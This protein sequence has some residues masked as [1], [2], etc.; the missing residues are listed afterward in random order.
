MLVLSD[1]KNSME[2]FVS[3]LG[4]RF[5]K[6]MKLSFEDAAKYDAMALIIFTKKI[7]IKHEEKGGR[8]MI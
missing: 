7:R 3:F 6:S 5:W 2:V 8:R 1:G 4:T